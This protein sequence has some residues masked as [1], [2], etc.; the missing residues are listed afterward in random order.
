VLSRFVTTLCLNRQD[1]KPNR[2]D[3]MR[4]I[5]KAGGM[6]IHKRVMGELAVSRAFGDR[7]FKM[8]IKVRSGSL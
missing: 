8:G 7:A 1:H 2:P 4:R 3:E 6:V 5:K